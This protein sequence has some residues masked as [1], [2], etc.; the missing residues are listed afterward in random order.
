MFF[1]LSAFLLEPVFFG[2]P[3]P[4]SPTVEGLPFKTFRDGRKQ[5]ADWVRKAANVL[6]EDVTLLLDEVNNL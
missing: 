2:K 4:F 6:G 3:L 1:F 5:E